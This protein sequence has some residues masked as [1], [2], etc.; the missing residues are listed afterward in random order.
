[1]RRLDDADNGD[2]VFGR[3]PFAQVPSP[4]FE[5]LSSTSL[6]DRSIRTSF[7]SFSPMVL[8]R[9][10]VLLLPAPAVALLYTAKL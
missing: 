5:V 7:L 4:S 8:K 10:L 9:I 3:D 6:P 2:T 1:M